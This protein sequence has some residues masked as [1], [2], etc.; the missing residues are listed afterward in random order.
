M[1]NKLIVTELRHQLNFDAKNIYNVEY[2]EIDNIGTIIINGHF[3]SSMHIKV[4]TNNNFEISYI[5]YNP[6]KRQQKITF[7]RID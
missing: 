1:Y 6:I 2:D 7:R 5:S 3:I 4:L